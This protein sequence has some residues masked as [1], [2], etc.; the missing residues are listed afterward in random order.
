MVGRALPIS[1]SRRGRL[2]HIQ[3]AG[4]CIA[5][6]VGI[7]RY[8]Q[9]LHPNAPLMGTGTLGQASVELWQRRME[10]NV[11]LPIEQTFLHRSELFKARTQVAEFAGVCRK[12]A[13]QGL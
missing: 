1:G 9:G 7:C 4:I 8:F 13:Y 11:F 3:E 10:L 2:T 6:S 12:K 5:A